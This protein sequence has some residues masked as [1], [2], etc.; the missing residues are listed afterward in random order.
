MSK[1]VKLVSIFCYVSGDNFEVQKCSR[2]YIYFR[3]H[4][5]EDGHLQPCE[6]ENIYM[7]LNISAPRS[8]PL[9]H[10][11][12]W[13]LVLHLSTWLKVINYKIS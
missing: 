10:S 3:P 6:A 8:Y 1:G 11:K 13:I 4:T 2:P 12:K 7:A 5:A 9:T